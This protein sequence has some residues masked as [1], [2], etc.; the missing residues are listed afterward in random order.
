MDVCGNC[1]NFGNGCEVTKSD[2]VNHPSHYTQGG[3]ECIK[4]IEASMTPYGFQDYCKGNVLK[5]IWRWREKNGVEDLKKAKVYLNWMIE[6]AIVS[7]LSAFEAKLL[8]VELD[9]NT[10]INTDTQESS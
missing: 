9:D 2:H 7:E 1:K 10:G 5:Y 8:K 4:A 6:S 3:I